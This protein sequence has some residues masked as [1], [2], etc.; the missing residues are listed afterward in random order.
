MDE[1]AV[2]ILLCHDHTAASRIVDGSTKAKIRHM[3]VAGKTRVDA[4]SMNWRVWHA[5]IVR[6]RQPDMIS[7]IEAKERMS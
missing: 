6:M 5:D 2:T 3:L 7:R 1:Q 4:G